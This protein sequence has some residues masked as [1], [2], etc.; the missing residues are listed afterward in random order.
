VDV[1]L[2]DGADGLQH[3][4]SGRYAVASISEGLTFVSA[5]NKA[6]RLAIEC[7]VSLIIERI[8]TYSEV[9]GSNEDAYVVWKARNPSGCWVVCFPQSMSTEDI[10]KIRTAAKNLF[11]SN[12]DLRRD[13]EVAF[14]KLLQDYDGRRSICDCEDED[15]DQINRGMQNHRHDL[16]LDLSQSEIWG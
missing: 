15:E 3:A 12:D 9:V 8:S 5:S 1:Y 10:Q 7:C 4:F 6:R 16:E 14:Q 2:F 11:R 13:D